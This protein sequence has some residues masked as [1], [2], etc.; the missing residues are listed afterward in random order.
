[1]CYFCSGYTSPKRNIGKTRHYAH[2][3]CMNEARKTLTTVKRDG[4]NNLHVI[5][6]TVIPLLSHSFLEPI[7]RVVDAMVLSK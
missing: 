4:R 7:H 2:Q 3:P 6:V 1:M 5:R